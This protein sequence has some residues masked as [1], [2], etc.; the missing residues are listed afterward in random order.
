M[1]LNTFDV[2]AL[3]DNGTRWA[4]QR[5]TD[6]NVFETIGN[7]TSQAAAQDECD[8][9]NEDVEAENE[10]LE[11][12]IARVYGAKREF[13][14]PVDHVGN[15]DQSGDQLQCSGGA[16]HVNGDFVQGGCS[17][18]INNEETIS[19]ATSDARTTIPAI[20]FYPAG[21]LGEAVESE[22]GDAA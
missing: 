17:S 1:I 12:E 18:C 21:S 9:L 10:A 16:V 11:E 7:F 14:Q 22:D 15:A 2:V 8:L 4:C 5:E 20:I 19:A 6:Y 3:D 13:S